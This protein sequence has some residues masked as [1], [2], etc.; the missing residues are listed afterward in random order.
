MK[1]VFETELYSMVIAGIMLMCAFSCAQ[2]PEPEGFHVTIELGL[3]SYEGNMQYTA[4]QDQ[5][6]GRR[7]SRMNASQTVSL[8]TRAPSA[9]QLELL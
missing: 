5:T 3:S 7:V 6:S 1:T 4:V 2:T 9:L 8:I